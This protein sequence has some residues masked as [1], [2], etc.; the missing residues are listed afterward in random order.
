MDR[1]K[2]RGQVHL[3]FALTFPLLILFLILT[4]KVFV[5]FGSSIVKRNAAY[6]Q[7]RTAT[8]A[9]AVNFYNESANKLNLFGH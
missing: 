8:A 4:V 9:P 6:Q 2:I 7:S 5:W 3:E 1:A